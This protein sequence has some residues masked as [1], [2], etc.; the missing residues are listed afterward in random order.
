MP[1]SAQ[2]RVEPIS[3]TLRMKSI[4]SFPETSSNIF[5]RGVGSSP[6]LSNILSAFSF[7]KSAFNGRKQTISS[8]SKRAPLK[9]VSFSILSHLRFHGLKK[10]YTVRFFARFFKRINNAG[11]RLGSSGKNCSRKFID[12][13]AFALLLIRQSYAFSLSKRVL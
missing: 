10:L 5:K 1:S 2:K 12:S 13:S 7:K 8:K 11:D 4:S 3:W 6:Q 9:T